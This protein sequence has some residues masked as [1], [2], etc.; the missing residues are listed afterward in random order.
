MSKREV[1]TSSQGPEQPVSRA[2]Q[3]PAEKARME[4]ERR[5][6][7]AKRQAMGESF[8]ASLRKFPHMA[9]SAGFLLALQGCGMA[10][11]ITFKIES[12][13][14]TR[15]ANDDRARATLSEVEKAEANKSYRDNI[16]PYK[17]KDEKDLLA[18]LETI[19][20]VVSGSG[21]RKKKE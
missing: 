16:D 2:M 17:A 6:Y 21:A 1:F 9:R 4:L 8:L 13:I 5:E 10:P 7:E 3:P 15:M 12:P 20:D 19:V 11:E 14:S 18:K